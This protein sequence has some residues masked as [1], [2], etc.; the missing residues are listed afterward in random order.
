MECSAD[1][2][3]DVDIPEEME[4]V[5]D[6]EEGSDDGFEERLHEESVQT[7]DTRLETT[8][9]L[10]EK[11]ASLLR[12]QIQYADMRFFAEQEK[13]LARAVGFMEDCLEVERLENSRILDKP[14]TWGMKSTTMYLRPRAPRDIT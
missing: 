6:D 3:A 4:G 13:Q 1:N 12:A 8:A 7:M 11:F 14:T 10:L 2:T 9:Q 5:G